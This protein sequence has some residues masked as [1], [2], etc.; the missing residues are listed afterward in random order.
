MGFCFMADCR[1][2]IDQYQEQRIKHSF[3]G[4]HAGYN[5]GFNFTVMFMTSVA[6]TIQHQQW[7]N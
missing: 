6:K 2:S 7:G 1:I 5:I 3:T 4:L